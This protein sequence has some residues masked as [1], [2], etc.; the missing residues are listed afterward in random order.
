M[1]NKLL[2]FAISF[3][4]IQALNAQLTTAVQGG[5]TK[6]TVA[7]RVGVTDITIHYDRPAVN[8][9]EGKI[10]NGIVHKGF[11]DLQFGTS[12][13]APWR[14]GA[15]ENTTFTFS[16]DVKI[17]GQ[18]LKAG[19]YGF[20]MAMGDQDATLIFSKN[21][22]SWG[23]YFYDPKEDALRVNVKTAP[24]N[25]S[26]ER[27]KYEFMNQTPSGTVIAL[28]W[29]KLKVPFKVEVDLVQ[30][31]MQSFREELRSDKGFRWE[32]WVEAAEFAV[33]NNTNLDEALEW[34]NY[35]INSSFPGQKNFKTLST[36]AMILDKMGKKAEADVLMKD[37]MPMANM[38]E[39][40]Q[41]GRKLLTEKRSREALEV[42][43]MNDKK[44]PNN[45]TTSMGLVR[46]YS[47]NG[48]YKNALKYANSASAIAP[49]KN[50]KDLV[51]GMIVKLE[52]GKD[53]N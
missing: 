7:E 23:S 41:Y 46:G 30:T 2:L 39:L 3:F 31:Q 18:P 6:A 11:S 36:K 26:V 45:F 15:N 21:H 4:T 9:R 49:N 51:A 10:W 25:E 12:K 32:S 29:E 19:T 8:G 17:E 13:S 35:S 22:S 47:A 16:T 27:L 50:S 53:V 43:I 33:Q 42:F 37:A 52:A 20:F 1:R 38:N 28:I 48:D 5:S 24:I 44:N 34:S 14:A 40:H